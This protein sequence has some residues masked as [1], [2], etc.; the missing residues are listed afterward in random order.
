[1]SRTLTAQDAA[2]ALARVFED[3]DF[4]VQLRL[5]GEWQQA[6]FERLVHAMEDV[7]VACEGATNVPAAVLPIF[8]N[9]PHWVE[10]TTSHPDFVRIQSAPADEVRQ[11]LADAHRRLRVLQR[12]F[13]DRTPWPR[14]NT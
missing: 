7:V 13:F 9:V 12:A 6:A 8:F 2:I 14:R 10:Q 5:T 1:M 11:W 3:D 4:V